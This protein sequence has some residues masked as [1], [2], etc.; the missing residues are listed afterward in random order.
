M[1]LLND[2]LENMHP[3]KVLLFLSVLEIELVI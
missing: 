2:P 1:D 3:L